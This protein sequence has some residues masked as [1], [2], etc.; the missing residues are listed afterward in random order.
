MEILG[1]V[2]AGELVIRVFATR[3][4]PI[5]R[6]SILASGQKS[7]CRSLQLRLLVRP[8]TILVIRV[9][10][11]RRYAIT[12]LCVRDLVFVTGGRC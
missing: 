6:L 12:K 11:I 9:L 7:R 10:E 2:E 8:N 4:R 5:S 1:R 3:Q